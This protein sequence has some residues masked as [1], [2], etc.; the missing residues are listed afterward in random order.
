MSGGG[1]HVAF[2]EMPSDLRERVAKRL[3]S[4]V[5]RLVDEEHAAMLEQLRAATRL[6]AMRTLEELGPIGS[7]ALGEY[8]RNPDGIAPPVSLEQ[9]VA[10]ALGDSP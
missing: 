8:E 4:V 9:G 5:A 7:A 3:E 6:E 1:P 10:R 2:R